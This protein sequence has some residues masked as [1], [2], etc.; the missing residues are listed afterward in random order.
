MMTFGVG[1][2]LGFG[3]GRRTGTRTRPPAQDPDQAWGCTA[4]CNRGLVG[5]LWPGC[6][7]AEWC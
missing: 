4:M 3:P 2:G 1:G 7:F 6:V 5:V